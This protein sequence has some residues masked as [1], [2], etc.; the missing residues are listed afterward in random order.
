MVLG[1]D[2]RAKASKESD[3]GEGEGGSRST[4]DSVRWIPHPSRDQVL[5]TL[6]TYVDMLAAGE[7]EGTGSCFAVVEPRG[8]GKTS[9]LRRLSCEA[10]PSVR[11]VTEEDLGRKKTLVA[12]V[13]ALLGD[14]IRLRADAVVGNPSLGRIAC[15]RSPICTT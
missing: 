12:A 5:E 11:I 4:G 10:P 15:S 6:A 2:T 8:T 14:L 7:L 9:L 1:C 13:I 3:A